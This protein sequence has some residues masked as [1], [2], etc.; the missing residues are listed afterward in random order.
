MTN[1]TLVGSLVVVAAIAGVC[2]GKWMFKAQCVNPP[3]QIPA[4]IQ[5]NQ[6]GSCSQLTNGVGDAIPHL[7]SR[8]AAFAGDTIVWSGSANGQITTVTVQFPKTTPNGA[9]GSPFGSAVAP[10]FTFKSGQ[11]SGPAPAADAGDYFFGT[12]TVGNTACSN[13]QPGGI[14]IDK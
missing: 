9:A 7:Q 4:V 12:V 2:A 10:V 5:L 3:T 14:H 8:Q 6:D 13:P 11:D 1:K